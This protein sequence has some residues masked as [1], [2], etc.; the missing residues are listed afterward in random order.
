M[1][2]CVGG[3]SRSRLSQ[4]LQTRNRVSRNHKALSRRDVLEW[5]FE[6][7]SFSTTRAG[8]I[9]RVIEER[10]FCISKM[11][12][13]ETIMNE[14]VLCAMCKVRGVCGKGVDRSAAAKAYSNPV[15]KLTSTVSW[16][17]IWSKYCYFCDKKNSG[18]IRA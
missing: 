6:A 18:L 16:P 8:D 14:V 15:D 12:P 2:C 9:I 1:N 4:T 10:A 5:E 7:F 13:E 17:T 11:Q 3:E